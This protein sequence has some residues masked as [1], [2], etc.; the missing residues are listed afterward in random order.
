M[1]S[2]ALRSQLSR[3][4]IF[5]VTTDERVGPEAEAHLASDYDMHTFQSWDELLAAHKKQPPHAIL[6]DI[7]TIGERTEDGIAALAE[8][9]STGP[10]LLLVALTRSS[11]RRTRHHAIHA[12][13]DE[14]FV[15]PIDFSEVSIVLNRALEKRAAEIEYRKEQQNKEQQ[16]EDVRQAFHGLIGASAVMQQLYDAITRVAESNTTLL[17]RG[18]SGTGKELVAHAIAALGSRSGK[19][20]IS[21]NCAAL[22]EN[23]IETELFGHERGAF[24]DANTARPGHIELAQSGTLFLDE[25]ATLGLALQSK[26]LRVLEDRVVTRIGGKTPKKI[27]FRLIT[28]TKQNLED[29]V[30]AGRFREDLYYRINVIPITLPPLRKRAE[31]IPLLI[32]HFLRLYSDT[33]RVPLKQMDHEVIEILEEYSWPGNIRELENLTQRLVLMVDG[34]VIMLLLAQQSCSKFGHWNRQIG[35]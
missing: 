1:H 19:P 23:L 25:I 18:E 21:I 6:L 16:N 27:D 32:N 17:I 7:D 13:V 11:S 26:L 31:D 12:S 35:A 30:H 24:T 2:A 33:N 9:R 29:L 34:A 20:F 14:Y 5:I 4:T 10:D 22:P 8:L 15:A 28:A 3:C